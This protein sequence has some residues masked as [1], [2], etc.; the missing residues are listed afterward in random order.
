MITVPAYFDEPR[1][2]ATADAGEMAGLSVLDIVN[3]PTAGALA[4]GEV[5][6]YLSPTAPERE[7][8]VVVY[9]L[10]GGT[11]DVTLLRLAPGVIQ[12]IATD[13]DVQLGGYDWDLRLVDYLAGVFQSPY[14]EDPRQ[15]AAAMS[16]LFAGR[17]TP[18]TRSA[19]AATPPSA[20]TMPGRGSTCRSRREKF[21]E[22]SA[23]LLE[24]TAYTTRQL[25]AAAKNAVERRLAAA[26][27]GR[28]HAD[29]DRARMLQ[30]ISG[31][32]PDRCV[33]P[34]EA[35]ARGAALYANFL[36]AGRRGQGPEFE[37]TNVNSHSLGIEGIEQET[38]RKTNMILIPRN[39]PLPA[40][41]TERFATKSRRAAID[42]GSGA[43]RRKLDA[44]RVYR[45]RPHGA[46]GPARRSCPKAGRSTSP[47]IT[48]RTAG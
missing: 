35:V 28:I 45:H 5:L 39:T 21:E 40:K 6:G 44:R 12:T 13:G 46:P 29:A 48:A 22:L 41:C 4:F 24:R 27:G 16:R 17:S 15:D 31:I 37:V 3:E 23:D 43:R 8:T 34:D 47:S 1:R 2:K 14:G 26:A 25:L 18:N 7:M 19:P 38:L 9:D 30:Q 36:L 10:G 42:R 33:N 20:W 32:E 11:F